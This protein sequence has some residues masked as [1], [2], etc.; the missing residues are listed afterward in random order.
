MDRSSKLIN[1][2]IYLLGIIVCCYLSSIA[3][4]SFENTTH[5]PTDNN[6]NTSYIH[7]TFWRPRRDHLNYICYLLLSSIV[8]YLVSCSTIY[9]HITMVLPSS[10]KSSST[11]APLQDVRQSM[12]A[13]SA[14]RISKFLAKP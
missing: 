13:A 2:T 6:P 11:R 7:I 8:V 12:N 10:S 5:C 1:M 9:K 14:S 4:L 3:L